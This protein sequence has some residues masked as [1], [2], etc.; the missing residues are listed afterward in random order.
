[1][2]MFNPSS[3]VILRLVVQQLFFLSNFLCVENTFITQWRE[4]SERNGSW[5]KEKK[6]KVG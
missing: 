4:G 1:M 3:S 2:I 5:I 6:K